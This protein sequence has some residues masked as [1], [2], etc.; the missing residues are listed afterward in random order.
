MRNGD[1]SVVDSTEVRKA[2]MG[3]TRRLWAGRRARVG[4]VRQCCRAAK[5]ARA[6]AGMHS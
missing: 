2:A 4:D 6:G 3:C 5:G 1:V